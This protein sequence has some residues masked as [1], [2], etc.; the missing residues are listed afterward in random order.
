[1]TTYCLYGV[2][3]GPTTPR[4][5][6]FRSDADLAGEFPWAA[7]PEVMLG[8]GDGTALLASLEACAGWAAVQRAAVVAVPLVNV[9]HTDILRSAQAFGVLAQVLTRPPD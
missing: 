7:A 9:S 3:P 5:L 6:R 2:L 4:A 8:D 1:M